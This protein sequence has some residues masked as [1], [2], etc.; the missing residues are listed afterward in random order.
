MGS[1]ANGIVLKLSPKYSDEVNNSRCLDVSKL[2]EFKGEKEKLFAGL[3]VLSITNI[4]NPSDN[5]WKGYGEYVS[6][7]LYFER[8]I[9][10][11]NQQKHH[12][13][14]GKIN[15][16]QQNKYLVPLIKHQM[17]RNGYKNNNDDEKEDNDDEIPPYICV[18]FEYFCD[19]KRDYIDLSCINEEISLMDESLQ[20][21]LFQN[22]KFG[23]HNGLVRGYKINNKNLKLIFPNLVEYKNH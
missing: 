12:H 2:S 20:N 17:N 4:Y 19:N 5:D 14:Y 15:R 3:T 10:Q 8:I 22:I 9:E 11:T 16:H 13:N 6:S 18:L 7:F 21:L 1:D 23:N